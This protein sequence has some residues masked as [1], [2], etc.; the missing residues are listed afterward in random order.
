MCI[1]PRFAH[2]FLFLYFLMEKDAKTL[3]K[4]ILYHKGLAK[5]MDETHNKYYLKE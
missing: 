2:F 5:L 1:F 4:V 3:K